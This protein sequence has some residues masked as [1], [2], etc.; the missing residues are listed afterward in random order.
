MTMM[1]MMAFW[2][3]LQTAAQSLRRDA[4]QTRRC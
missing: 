4:S 1:T 2:Y 3:R